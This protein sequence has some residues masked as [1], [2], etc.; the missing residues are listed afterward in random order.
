MRSDKLL[1]LL[2]LFLTCSPLLAAETAIPV[3]IKADQ[4]K[5]YEN[6]DIV[7]ASGSVEVKLKGVTIRS[8][9]LRMDSVTNIATA[10][11]N[12]ILTADDYTAAAGSLIYDADKESSSFSS[13]EARL[14]PVALKGDLYINSGQMTEVHDKLSGGPAELSTCGRDSQHYYVLADQIGYFPDDHIEGRNV[15]VYVGSAPV[16]W[17]PVFYYDLHNQQKRNWTFGHN[18]VE[19]NYVKTAWDYPLGTLLIDLMDKKGTGYGTTTNY[20]L[21]ALG[22]GS[23]YLYHLDEKDTGISDWVEKVSQEKMIN[24][25]TKLKLNQSY[26]STYLIPAGRMDQTTF[27]LGLNYAEKTSWG[28]NFSLLDDRAANYGN[29]SLQLDQSAGPLTSNYSN[30]Y[31]YAKNDPRWLRDS[32]R[33]NLNLKLSDRVNLSS[34]TNYYH[35]SPGSGNPGQ[36][37][38]EPQIELT[39]NEPDF[40]W[41]YTENWFVDLRQNLY[42]GAN[43]YESLQKQ[44]E[45][46]IS[47]RTLDLKLFNLQSTFGYGYYRE[48]RKVPQLGGSGYRDFSSQR[49]RATVNASKSVPLAAGT[50]LQLGSGLDQ[51]YYGPG[52]ELYAFRESA[53]LQTDLRSCFRNSLN[54]RQAY[55]EGNTPFFFDRLNTVYH[56]IT[57]QMTFY[58]LDK[59][60]WDISGGHNWQT[61]KYYNVMTD[62]TLKLDPRWRL[63]VNTGWDIENTRYLNMLAGV[64]FIPSD[65][66][67]LDFNLTQ[68]LNGAGLQSASALHDLYILKGADN[69]MRLRGSQ[70]FDPATKGFRI[71][72]IMIVKQL[73][74]WEMS[75]AYSDYRKDYSFTFSLKALPG[76]P[77]G[78]SSTSGFSFQGFQQAIDQLNPQGEVRRY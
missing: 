10:E 75:F 23:L 13:F 51:F 18:E 3:D 21:A 50:T 45:L 60:N 22:L 52:D 37:K 34:M 47:P 26:V 1:V 39:G 62:L 61:N 72:D 73:H 4:L 19:G 29:Y 74:C 54:F 64:G 2:F 12:V 14:S 38:V 55:T 30:I 66:Y 48:V 16:L 57:E 44:P 43:S 58:Y 17:L 77:A 78:F 63:H 40:S 32:Q 53:G 68:D 65:I 76:E 71:G 24:P 25:N 31:E 56:D 6:S 9:R 35:Y 8:D 7:E 69:E 36:E 59:F 33:F 49:T 28:G 70:V 5:Y 11:G 46:E 41:H 27:G 20:A 42:P 67:N 15:T